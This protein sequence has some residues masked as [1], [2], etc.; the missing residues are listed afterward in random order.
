MSRTLKVTN[1]DMVRLESNQGYAFVS[2]KEKLKQDVA[3]LFTTGIRYSTGL[4]FGLDDLVG[5]DTMQH[6]SDFSV[7]PAAFD[8]QEGI[9]LG[10]EKLKGNQRMYFYA[11]RDASELLADWK[12][13]RVWYS[14]VDP[15]TFNWSIS[16][17]SEEGKIQA[18]SGTAG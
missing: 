1:G 13:A 9:T 8:F 12:P 6:T 7:Y 3:C 17:T 15:R 18:L 11:D 2:G 16:F 10:M 4:G 5:G 14:S